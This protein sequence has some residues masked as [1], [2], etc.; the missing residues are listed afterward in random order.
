[1]QEAGESSDLAKTSDLGLQIVGVWRH[2]AKPF[3]IQK[4][5]HPTLVNRK[6]NHEAST[7]FEGFSQKLQRLSIEPP[8][9]IPD[10]EEEEGVGK[11]LEDTAGT[12]VLVTHIVM[13]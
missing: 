4:F 8:P 2:E 11:I 9:N 7:Y 10:E 3:S 13:K 6:Q 5:L 1:M 12:V